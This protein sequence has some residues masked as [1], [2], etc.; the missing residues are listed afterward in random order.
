MPTFL[1]DRRVMRRGAAGLCGVIAAVYLAIAA[2]ATS[3]EPNEEMSLAT[4]GVG[5]ASIYLVGAALLLAFDN[6]VLWGLGAMMQLMI[7]AMYLAVSSDRSPA[8]EAWGIGLRVLQIPL[9]A[10]LVL[11]AVR[12]V[13]PSEPG[14]DVTSAPPIPSSLG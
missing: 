10:L 8:F 6:R 13:R 9:F 5:A 11:L 4:F 12:A 3:I 14:H 1:R 7:A 2:G